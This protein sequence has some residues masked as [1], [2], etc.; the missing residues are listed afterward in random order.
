MNNDIHI[1]VIA[2]VYNKAAFV[3]TALNSLL[4]QKDARFDAIIIDDG[5]DDGSYEICEKTVGGH[6][7]I[8]VERIVHGGV[9]SARNYGLSL[10]KTEY[11][12]F[13][14]GDDTLDEYAVKTLE[15]EIALNQRDL[16]VFGLRHALK[17]GQAYDILIDDIDMRSR[18]DISRHLTRMWDSELMYSVCNKVFRTALI[19][20][21]SMSFQQ[22]D[23][24]EDFAFNREYLTYCKN[25]RTMSACLYGYTF[26]NKSS[27]SSRHRTELFE[28]RRAE[29]VEML[30]YFRQ[31]GCEDAQAEEFLSRRHIE[32]VVGCIE[33]ECSS[34]NTK[35]RKDKK[36]AIKRIILDEYSQ[37][38]AKK[39][40][41][42]GMKMKTLVFPI[43]HKLYRTAYLFG[44]IMS[45]CLEK[46]PNLFA[47]LKANRYKK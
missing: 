36:A 19:K 21:H 26:H 18:S 5:S 10:V 17:N 11:V 25:V 38:C 8:R 27:L 45:V 40:V 23:F 13:L 7:G 44:K 32:R 41:L 24:G 4:A 33:N 9:A 6:S 20:E 34:F 2:T 31:F 39:A 12:T 16:I 28:I 47:N 1:T 46:T 3:K 43:K 22:R 15:D 42:S 37:K 29:H 35:K 14:D 30:E